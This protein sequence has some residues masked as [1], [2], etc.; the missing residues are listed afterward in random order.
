MCRITFQVVQRRM[1]QKKDLL[2]Q[3]HVVHFLLKKQLST[4]TVFFMS[5]ACHAGICRLA[6]LLA[7]PI[8]TCN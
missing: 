6:N 2:P 1:E 7:S 5:K 4:M 3:M 8:R